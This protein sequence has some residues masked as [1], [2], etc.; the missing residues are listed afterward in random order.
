MTARSSVAHAPGALYDGALPQKK[1]MRWSQTDGHVPFT[2]RGR[3]LS[4]CPE[5]YISPKA[6]NPFA[7]CPRLPNYSMSRRVRCNKYAACAHCTRALRA[8]CPEGRAE[9]YRWA[10]GRR[11]HAELW[12]VSFTVQDTYRGVTSAYAALPATWDILGP[13]RAHRPEG[14]ADTGS[15]RAKYAQ[16]L[17]PFTL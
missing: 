4:Q 8:Q 17:A 3:L 1:T 16:P 11:A 15:S 9:P 14:C 7:Q 12:A 13:L 6:D 10:G 2:P 5:G